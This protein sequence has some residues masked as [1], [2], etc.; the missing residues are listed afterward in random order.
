MPAP[1]SA[2][3]QQ[4]CTAHRTAT[5]LVMDTNIVLDMLVFD[6][7]HAPPLLH[8]LLQ[9]QVQWLAT[10]PMRTEL[11]RV[12]HYPHIAQRMSC[13]GRTGAS[14]LAAFDAHSMLHATAPRA[15]CLCKDTDDQK[16]IDL[17]WQHRAA[18][19][20]KDRAV[21]KLHKRLTRN[22]SSALT[23]EQFN[24]DVVQP[25]CGTGDR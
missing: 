5:P 19:L 24:A 21:L 23:L 20:S 11:E 12:L 15:P 10:L 7:P 25:H 3:T 13:H 18:L 8:L 2:A 17:A 14:V 9:Q 1:L 16:F 22:G 4:H 6:N